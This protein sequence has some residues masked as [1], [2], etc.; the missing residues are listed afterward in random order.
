MNYEKTLPLVSFCTQTY[1]SARWIV[2][3]LEC[4]KSQTYPNIELIVSDDC[5]TDNT[6]ELVRDWMDKNKSRFARCVFVSTPHNLGY[7]GN[8][9]NAE[10]QC[11]GDYIKTI[12]SDDWID[13]TFIEKAV[14]MLE[15]H[16]DCSFLY[17]NCTLVYD[18]RREKEQ[19]YHVDGDAFPALFM[20]DFWPSTPTWFYRREVKESTFYRPEMFLSEDY[21]R[22]LEIAH[23][24]RFC[25]LDEYL[26]YYRRYD[27]EEDP[28]KMFRFFQSQIMAINYFKDYP[29]YDKRFEKIK[30]QLVEEA[31]VTKPS[32][33]LNMAFQF[34]DWKYVGVYLKFE[35]ARIKAKIKTTRLF[36][37][38]KGCLK[39]DKKE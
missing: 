3:L 30:R 12:D 23:E 33:L 4:A 37:M 11:Q 8:K 26:A 10:K 19:S 20:V 32:Y 6:V 13:D 22:I 17:S 14:N 25:H 34:K 28:L 2:G 9:A 7:S 18:D 29:L 36:K 31:K 15:E 38:V 39:T 35:K 27:R 21:L 24:Y 1:N 5:S 16:K